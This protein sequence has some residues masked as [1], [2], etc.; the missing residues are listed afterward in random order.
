MKRMIA[1]VLAMMLLAVPLALAD[2]TDV[3]YEGPV[4]V[5]TAPRDAELALSE[6]TADSYRQVLTSPGSAETIVSAAF[7]S[8]DD[9]SAYIGE[10]LGDIA[11][12]AAPVAEPDAVHGHPAQRFTATIG[13]PEGLGIAPFLQAE[14]SSVVHIV[15]IDARC[16]YLFVAAMPEDVYR[17]AADG[18][19]LADVIEAQIESLELFDP[20]ARLMLEPET[21][22]NAGS[23]QLA[24]EI[25]Q[26]SE[27]DA[28]LVYALDT[29]RNVRLTSV[30]LDVNGNV[31]PDFVLGEWK[32]LMFGEAIRIQAWLP[33]VLPGFA[34]IYTDATGLETTL[35]ITDS[36]LDGTL[37]LVNG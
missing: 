16:A 15:T 29:I 17:G 6:M 33:D 1:A 32:E 37:M 24:G 8:A 21:E 13:T 10:L 9:R 3:L 34:I 31:A 27:A 30:V 14:A 26:N 35:Y 18:E 11:A 4:L 5:F 2:E 28:F 7:P 36:G 20:D 12:T 19:G 22:I 23:Y 25:I